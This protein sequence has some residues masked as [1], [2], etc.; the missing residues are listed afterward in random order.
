[1]NDSV[2]PLPPPPPPPPSSEVSRHKNPSWKSGLVLGVSVCLLLATVFAAVFPFAARMYAKS[3]VNV[4]AAIPVEETE[5]PTKKTDDLGIR[6]FPLLTDEARQAWGQDPDAALNQAG[7]AVFKDQWPDVLDLAQNDQWA[8]NL[9]GRVQ[10]GGYWGYA[11]DL[12][13]GTLTT[14]G[15]SDDERIVDLIGLLLL[16]AET[17]PHDGNTMNYYSPMATLAFALADVASQKYSTCD[18]LMTRAYAFGLDGYPPGRP[19][20]FRYGQGYSIE[21]W[22][23]AAISACGNDPTPRIEEIKSHFD[24][25]FHAAISAAH[26]VDDAHLPQVQKIVDEYPTIAASH[27]L[28]GD[29]YRVLADVFPANQIGPFTVQEMRS[30]AVKEY[31]AAANLSNEPAVLVAWADALAATGDLDGAEDA[32]SGVT[33]K[34]SYRQALETESVILGLRHRYSDS[35]DAMAKAINL[36]PPG[37]VTIIQRTSRELTAPAL[38]ESTIFYVFS[39][40]AGGAASM[41]DNFGFVPTSRN[42]YVHFLPAGSSRFVMYENVTRSTGENLIVPL[43]LSQRF[44]DAQVLCSTA[45]SDAADRWS[46]PVKYIQDE[47]CPIANS[48]AVP[49]AMTDG[50]NDI[51]QDMWRGWRDYE[52]ALTFI[53]SWIA[54]DSSNPLA[55]ERAGEVLF[56]MQRWEESATESGKAV[57][58]YTDQRTGFQKNV[59]SESGMTEMTGPG[60]ARLRQATALRQLD[61]FDDAQNSFS[62][63]EELQRQYYLQYGK[64]STYFSEIP[65]LDMYASQESAQVSYAEKDYDQ[66]LQKATQSLSWLGQTGKDDGDYVVKSRGAQEHL[67]GLSCFA[68]GQYEEALD[69]ANQAL[70]FD[71]YS[72]LY[73]E[74]VADAQRAIAGGGASPS[75]SATESEPIA[76][77]GTPPNSPNRTDL[78][79]TYQSALALDPTLFSSWNNLGVLLAQEGQIDEAI[80]AFKQAIAAVPDYPYAWFNLG[81]VAA[82]RPGM[83][84][85]TLS[86]GALGKAGALDSQW[87]NRDAVLTFDDEVY[88]SGLDVSKDIPA[89]WHLS[90]TVRSNPTLLTV[91]LVAMIGLRL[92]RDLGKDWFSGRWAE[93]ALRTWGGRRGRLGTLV[94]AKPPSIVT[95]LISLAALL[96]LVGPN[97]WREFV[98]VAV[99]GVALLGW[100]EV[101]P[102]YVNQDAPTK[103]VSWLPASAAT[104][105]LAPFGLGF[106]PPAPLAGD[107]VS[108]KVSRAGLVAV[109]AVTC[110][111]AGAA[112]ATSVPVARAGSMAGLLVVSSAL[113][114]IFP[115]DGA[116]LSLGRWVSLG[117]TGFLAVGTVATALGWL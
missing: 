95:M 90:Q 91:G 101:M 15:Q 72:P 65:L 115:L 36:A 33:I 46:N 116:R 55:H 8:K 42:S 112:I 18:M 6:T 40:P 2:I 73:T 71:P 56:L 9:N 78:I 25:G 61:R 109:A 30:S 102:W 27:L 104:L 87:K 111:L 110:V 4:L 82:S 113:V 103:H 16:K 98:M 1:M 66:A 21:P 45:S 11:S 17:L 22:W 35:A 83:M 60:W 100:H 28:L 14:L 77:S 114:P 68:L 105:V 41:V 50:S 26:S 62:D 59:F 3:A 12:I 37:S 96:W 43:L 81:V 99:I 24:E 51:Y 92:V 84:N 75:P 64:G 69:W 44:K 53:N 52:G 79:E 74:A 5:N 108:V 29:V 48:S 86:Q 31:A 20:D 57:D 10:P 32:L 80:D 97:G 85:F 7:Q 58:L 34:D 89:E 54:A 88:Q 76:P 49:K 19:D 107:G 13:Q 93:G 38:S 63:I 94:L 23:Q 39:G 106:T 47:W 67:A 117:V 70:A